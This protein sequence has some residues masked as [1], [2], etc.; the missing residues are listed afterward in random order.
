[1][2]R[3]PRSNRDL[4]RYD[5]DRDPQFDKRK[6]TDTQ[7]TSISMYPRDFEILDD[8]AEYFGCSRS[9]AVRTAVRHLSAAFGV[10]K[11]KN[12]R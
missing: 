4:K 8:L 10:T 6:P 5:Y 1:M 3:A 2:P 7:S 12:K 9:E 11:G